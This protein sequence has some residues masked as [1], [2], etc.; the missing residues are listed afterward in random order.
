MTL[1]LEASRAAVAEAARRL[2][3]DR[4]VTGTAGNVSARDPATGHVA[5]TPSGLPYANMAAEDVVLVDA[6][7]ALVDGDWLPS[8]ELPMHLAVYRLRADVLA[9]VH[10]HSPYATAFAACRR[11]IPAI[12]YEISAIANPIRVA[13]YATYGTDELARNACRTMGRDDQ[14]VLLQNHGVLA[15]GASV[16]R[17][18]G[19]AQ[20]VEYLAELYARALQLGDPVILADDEIARVR[21]KLASYGQRK[22][23]P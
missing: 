18:Y 21:A 9:I 14:A 6:S 1:R 19:V 17:A 8:S 11:E 20:K 3:L 22:P 10:T 23:S 15:V 2:V 7:G 13:P 16:E 5:I 4:L 12:H